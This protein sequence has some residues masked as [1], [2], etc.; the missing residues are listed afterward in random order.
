MAIPHL[1][2]DL[3]SKILPPGPRKSGLGPDHNEVDKFIKTTAGGP[4]EV[5]LVQYLLE[6]LHQFGIRACT[7]LSCVERKTSLKRIAPTASIGSQWGHIRDWALVTVS[8]KAAF[9]P[10]GGLKHGEDP[11]ECAGDN[12]D[13]Y[14][15]T[16]RCNND[17]KHT[18]AAV[19]FCTRILTDLG[20]YTTWL[21][22]D[23]IDAF[24][25][26]ELLLWISISNGRGR[27][28]SPTIQT[29]LRDRQLS[30]PE[31]RDGI[32]QL[33]SQSVCQSRLWMLAEAT[34]WG[35]CSLPSLLDILGRFQLS[36]R[37]QTT[38]QA[39]NPQTCLLSDV[40][41]TRID[42][43]HMCPTGHCEE[44]V[45]NGSKL[46]ELEND[47]VSG[48]WSWNSQ[49]MSKSLSVLP[50]LRK[51][52]KFVKITN[53][54]TYVA[55]SHV[56][57]DGTGVGLKKPGHIN[58]CLFD[59]FSGHAVKLGCDVIWWDTICVPTDREQRQ[60]ALRR[61]HHNFSEAKYT[62]IHDSELVNFVW[63]NDG[64]PCIALALST[65]FTRGWTA[66]E[67]YASNS[68]KI[69]FADED[70]NP[71]IKDLDDE[72]LADEFD[73]FAHPA[74]IEVSAVIR[75][76]RKDK[77]WMGTG[78]PI[79]HILH[80]LNNR[81]TCWSQDRVLIAGLMADM[82]RDFNRR[83][84]A[85]V[86]VLIQHSQPGF[87]QA[88]NTK[89]ILRRLEF[90]TQSSLLHGKVTISRAGAWSW[91]PLSFFDLSLPTPSEVIVELQL[92]GEYEGCLRGTWYS[93][94]LHQHDIP[95]LA[96]V[97]DHLSTLVRIQEALTALESHWLLAPWGPCMPIWR[98]RYLLVRD[99]GSNIVLKNNKLQRY[100]YVGTLAAEKDTIIFGRMQTQ[101]IL[102][103]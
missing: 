79:S 48:G 40:N 21:Q 11:F 14:G 27:R 32:L 91:C 83:R 62:L 73:P 77:F 26:C 52:P 38:H 23:Q 54:T 70:D 12:E 61:M 45:C 63:K 76:V 81:Y 99:I 22:R 93:T 39:C 50:L 43:L 33:P 95:Q 90:I 78:R 49:T 72:V 44:I 87:D 37:H 24:G 41:A 56:W 2:F 28:Q 100:A 92:E 36:E 29:I 34:E 18:H 57:S 35:M 55:I 102:L 82:G 3:P 6:S 85:D 42:Q 47:K 66:L 1:I 64:S 60:N 17:F 89:I 74:W 101:D 69:L 13:A 103:S 53:S 8:C 84:S 15:D 75:R 16:E 94:P 80:I 68:V 9:G 20:K 5:D 10:H 4:D 31:V 86:A 98:D 67:L 46:N 88:E 59:F 51:T 97:Y 30:I 65:W 58:K 19:Y 96:P 71:V 25:L 7:R